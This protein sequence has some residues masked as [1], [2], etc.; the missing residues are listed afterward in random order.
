M[1]SKQISNSLLFQFKPNG[2]CLVFEEPEKAQDAIERSTLK[3]QRKSLRSGSEKA[4]VREP[5]EESEEG[6]GF[7]IQSLRLY[8]SPFLEEF[9]R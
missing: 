5:S 3:R 2:L 4:L 9:P 6:R 7:G 8:C 1:K